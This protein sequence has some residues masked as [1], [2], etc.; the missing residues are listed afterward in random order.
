MMFTNLKENLKHASTMG[1]V[2]L[3]EPLKGWMASASRETVGEALKACVM[4]LTGHWAALP[5][6]LELAVGH[7]RQGA[8]ITI[9]E[10]RKALLQRFHA[11]M[12]G[13]L[14]LVLGMYSL[15]YCYLS[16]EGARTL[17]HSRRLRTDAKQRL[18]ETAAFVNLIGS[19]GQEDAVNEAL[20]R[21]RLAHGLARRLV[22]LHTPASS[23][24]PVNQLEIL[25]TGLAFSTVL[26]RGL[27]KMNMPFSQAEADA[28]LELW[29]QVSAALGCDEHILPTTTKQAWLAEQTI[30]ELCFAPSTES[31]EL[32]H[33]LVSSL[34]AEMQTSAMMRGTLAAI[35]GSVGNAVAW[36]LGP[37]HSAALGLTAHTAAQLPFMSTRMRSLG[38]AMTWQYAFR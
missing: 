37:E 16:A 27:R 19:Q 33:A 9:E 8:V 36:F 14:Y 24:M 35:G 11:R 38:Q 2:L 20:F 6:D 29:V 13:S 25:G 1:D 5:N 7:V 30:S 3:D 4:P 34:D 21:V 10:R 26:L 15:P 22:Q 31:H 23:V 28:W 17:Y 12:G 18:E 32:M